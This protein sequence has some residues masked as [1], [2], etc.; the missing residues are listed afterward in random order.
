[1]GYAIAILP[2]LLLGGII[3]VCDQ[4]LDDVKR[5]GKQPPVTGSPGKTFARFGAAAW[6]ERRTAF[7]DVVKVAA[8]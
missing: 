7:R 8:E 2:G 4:L 3:A 6:D 1:M 5:L